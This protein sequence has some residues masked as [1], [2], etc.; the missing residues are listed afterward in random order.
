ML[1]DN[2]SF[3]LH[4]NVSVVL[5]ID[6]RTSHWL[7]SSP[8]F[9]ETQNTEMVENWNSWVSF[10]FKYWLTEFSPK[11][12]IYSRSLFSFLFVSVSCHLSRQCGPTHQM[13]N[14]L[15]N[16]ISEFCG[17]L[18][19]WHIIQPS[20]FSTYSSYRENREGAKSWWQFSNK[21]CV[22]KWGID[23]SETVTGYITGIVASSV[24]DAW[25]ILEAK[26]RI[27]QSLL[28]WILFLSIS[29]D[30]SK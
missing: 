4:W 18:P 5:Q 30:G 21:V 22:T 3:P 9:Q 14:T 26:A 11:K 16:W 2:F 6:W 24:S 27:C 13:S 29:W 15:L 25:A 17:E 28:L 12:L 19:E 20:D 1:T 23:S 7:Q 8:V 10:S